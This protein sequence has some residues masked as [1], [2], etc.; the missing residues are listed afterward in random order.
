M[1]KDALVLMAVGVNGSWKTPLGYFLIDSL[2]GKERA[3]LIRECL[4]RL[5]DTGVTVL[6]LTCDGPSCHLTMLSEL[7]A[8]LKPDNLQPSFPHPAD[9]TSTVQVMLD[10]CH[11]LKLVRNTFAEGLVTKDGEDKRITWNLIEAL[12][13]TQVDEGL[14]LAN[15]IKSGHLDWRKQKMTVHLAAQVFSRSVADAIMYCDK[16]LNH[17]SF[18]DSDGTVS[19]LRRFDEMFDLLNSRNPCGKG[20][21]AP[22]KSS[23]KEQVFTLI[24]QGSKY[25]LGLKAATGKRLVD[26]KRKT[27][28]VGFLVSPIC[29]S[30]V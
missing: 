14:R 7:G 28:F 12:H 3:N 25:I 8:C 27:G 24:D 10:A 17:P 2:S 5:Y 21:K 13:V 18:S 1:A 23:N 16:T 26:G 4:H 9:A 11:M 30:S 22:L 29:Q 15:K 19:F 20:S 6:S